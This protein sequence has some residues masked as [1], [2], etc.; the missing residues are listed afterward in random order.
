VLG[1][2]NERQETL[3]QATFV[4]MLLPLISRQ[5]NKDRDD[6]K[7][8]RRLERASQAQE[9]QLIFRNMFID[10]RDA[11]IARVLSNY[12]RCVQKKWGDYWTEV[13]V[14]YIL[15]RTTGFRGLMLFLPYAY[16]SVTSAG[17]VPSEED[18]DSI[19]HRV[20]IRGETFTPDYYAPGATGQ[21]QLL[22]ELRSQTG[23]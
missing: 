2:A 10:D 20:Q 17:G 9:Q 19:F 22:R 12:F 14:G 1:T 3:S 4:D 6:L 15:N 7:R 13:R 21:T 5:P 8:G 11:D 16:L 18:F 23:L